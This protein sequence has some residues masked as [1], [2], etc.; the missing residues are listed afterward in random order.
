MPFAIQF[1]RGVRRARRITRAQFD[2]A[3]AGTLAGFTLL[4]RV[5]SQMIFVDGDGVIPQPTGAT[6]PP[7][8]PEPEPDPEA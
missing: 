4:R 1:T 5:N 7:P 3:I 2:G 6:E 8:C